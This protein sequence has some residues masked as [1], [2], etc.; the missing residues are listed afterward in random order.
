MTKPNP[1]LDARGCPPRSRGLIAILALVVAVFAVASVAPAASAQDPGSDQYSPEPTQPGNDSSP[2]DNSSPVPSVGTDT[3]GPS[4]SDPAGSSGD[5]AVAPTGVPEGSL[6]TGDGNR[7]DRTL[8]GLAASA[9]QQRVERNG[10]NQTATQLSSGGSSDSSGIG[11]FVWIVLAA[12]VLWAVG[13]GIVNYRRR[14]GDRS[15]ESS[16]SSGEQRT[17]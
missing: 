1:N 12:I 8:D 16:R 5:P 10:G 15:R 17:A 14:D 4:G 2:D 7:D 11:V 9:E 6:S 13:A 3:G